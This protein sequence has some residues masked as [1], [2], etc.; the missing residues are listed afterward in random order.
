MDPGNPLYSR[1]F[2]GRLIKWKELWTEEV[3]LPIFLKLLGSEAQPFAR[4]YCLKAP[5]NRK[6]IKKFYK[7]VN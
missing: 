1:L 2:W 6:D 3:R 7:F 4:I 5:M